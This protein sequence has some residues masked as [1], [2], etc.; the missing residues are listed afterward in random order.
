MADMTQDDISAASIK[1]A[2]AVSHTA[3]HSHVSIETSSNS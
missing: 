3:R 2:L 1:K